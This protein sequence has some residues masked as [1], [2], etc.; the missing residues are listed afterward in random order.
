YNDTT[1][2]TTPPTDSAC[3]TAWN[4]RCRIVI[5]YVKHIQALWDKPR[6]IIDPMTM[7]V[8]ADHTC[9]SGGCHSPVDAA[10]AAMVPAGQL[11]LTAVASDEQPLQLRSYRELFF[12][13]NEQALV[14]G[15]LVDRLVPGPP[16]ENGNPTQVTV[17]VGPYLN[18]GSAR[19]A[20]SAAFL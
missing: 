18:G 10:N 6:Q 17:G 11:D 8:V 4:A 1:F 13:D 12:G 14:G 5:N 7:L 16:D 19:G 15:A 3:V 9:T 20:R 2:T